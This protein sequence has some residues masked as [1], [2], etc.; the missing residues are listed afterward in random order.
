[1]MRSSSLTRGLLAEDKWEQITLPIIVIAEMLGVAAR[2]PG[3]VQALVGC[4]VADLQH[5]SDA[6]A[7]SR[8]GGG[9]AGPRGSGRV[10]FRAQP[11]CHDLIAALALNDP[12]GDGRVSRSMGNAAAGS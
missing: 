11:H 7:D 4:T 5:G 3:A 12:G 10:T 2:D 8:V 1:M 9:A 6:R